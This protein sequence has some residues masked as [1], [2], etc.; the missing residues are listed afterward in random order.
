MSS[1]AALPLPAQA[2]PGQATPVPFNRPHV[3]G[4]EQAFL[5]EAIGNRAIGSDGRFSRLCEQQL[6]ALT[7]AE[8]VLLTSSCTAA[9]EMAALLTGIGP[10]DEVILPSFT[11]PS[12]ANAFLLRG[13]RVVFADIE[14]DTLSLDIGQVAA[15]ITPR[16]R[17]IVAVHY[18]G[19][20]CDMAALVAL[21]RRHGIW[22]IEDAAQALLSSRDGRPAGSLA[23]LAA[24]S[25]HSTKN[26]SCGEG[27]ALAIN[28]PGLLGK[29][30]VLRDKGT[31][32]QDFL[33]GRVE[34]YSWVGVGSASVLGELP[35]AYLHAQLLQAQEITEA[36]RRAWQDYADALAPLAAPGRVLVPR[37]PAGVRHNGHCYYLLM[38]SRAER[39][40]LI[41]SLRAAGIEATTHYEPLHLAPAGRAFAGDRPLPLSESL[42]ARLLRLPLWPGLPAG[43]AGRVAAVVAAL[44]A[45]R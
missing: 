12:T 43:T 27:G 9:L 13:A 32:R 31:N 44:P 21:G 40:L 38:A 33:A 5:Q 2:V 19:V 37:I 4:R 23:D 35:A 45:A 25:F 8:S 16:T 15:A 7:G 34:K 22:V 14:A 24:F 18:G 6:R 30:L 1:K 29:A 42:P 36:R 39:D 17:A 26:I 10:G 28:R 20:P 3:T 41:R 11:F